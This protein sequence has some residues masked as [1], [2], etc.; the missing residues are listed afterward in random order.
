MTTDRCQPGWEERARILVVDDLPA[1]LRLLR[2]I[3]KKQYDVLLAK[4]GRTALDLVASHP[5][6]LILLDVVLPG[7][8]GF[9]VCRRIRANPDHQ[10]IP[11]LFVTSLGD[12][13]EENRGLELGAVDYLP[14]PIQASLVLARVRNHLGIRRM[15]RE[16]K[17]LSARN[18]MI[19][20]SAGDG[21][22]GVNDL[23]ETIFI[24]PAA[25]RL[26]GW[27][28]GEMLG[29]PLESLVERSRPESGRRSQVSC[30]TWDALSGGGARQVARDQFW[31]KD[32]SSL[33]VEYTINPIVEQERVTGAVMVFKDISWRL[34]LERQEVA[35]MASR[36]A[37]SALL[38]T[39]LESITLERQ[40]EVALEIIFSVPWL[41]LMKKGALFLWDEEQQVLEMRA[42]SNLPPQQLVTCARVE[43]GR[44]LCGR[45]AK[46][47]QVLF[48]GCVNHLHE[49][50]YDGMED[51]GHYTVPILRGKTLLGVMTF[52]VTP[53]HQAK[54]G[55]E[56]FLATAAQTLANLINHRRLEGALEEAH[57]RLHHM[58]HHD[59]LT[60]LPNRRLFEDFLERAL[61]L[62]QRERGRLA[63]MYLDLDHFK[64][65]NDFF[66]HET[67]DL[68]LR[69]VAQRLQ[70]LLR[71]SDTVARLGGDEFAIVLPEIQG[72]DAAV[73]VAIKVIETLG[74]PFKVGPHTCRIGA[75]VGIA[76]FPDHGREQKTLLRNADKA[77]YQVK[78]AGR[79]DYRVFADP[80]IEG[81]A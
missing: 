62:V 46:E 49:I 37:L 5:P 47:R 33:P 21:I 7:M 10:D 29:D 20:Q 51:H 8:D 12:E 36:L 24:N 2:E 16:I 80:E 15:I 3:L 52:Y 38:E 45:V 69:Q 11:I 41:S 1:N 9:E 64:P 22:I 67:G 74:R 43:P 13:A 17:R 35:G 25:R 39:G 34:E 40:L 55:E 78:D 19:L 73:L 76:L 70:G 18:E 60:G 68:L 66:G 71:E 77:L 65:V 63:V 56:A 6:D 31:R 44:C 48:A 30:S 61:A 79:N 23:G 32:G 81:T 4:D 75:S 57:N 58:A 27:A 72:R 59:K 53:G 14:K 50:T 42:S 28:P 54:P 26:M